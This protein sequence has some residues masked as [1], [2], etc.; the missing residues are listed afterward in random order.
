MRIILIPFFLIFAPS[1]ISSQNVLKTSQ[2]QED[3]KYFQ[4]TVNSD[5][6][7][8]FKKVT[9][10]EFNLAA[11]NLI[12][13]LPKL[14]EHEIKVRI[15]ELVALFK[16]GHT[17]LW[18]S[19]WRY[20]QIVKFRQL[21]Y[22]LYQFKDGVYV[23][24]VHKDYSKA[25]G[26]K[27]IKIGAFST[28]EALARIKPVV[29]VENDQFFKAYGLNY[30][31]VP[32]ILN[33]KGI[34]QDMNR[35][36]LTLERNGDDF[37]M[38]F[39]ARD[40]E[41]FPGH[42]GFVHTSEE[43][44]SARKS[45][46][47][48]FWLKKLDRKYFYEFLKEDKIIYVRQSEVQDEEDKNLAAFYEEVFQF[49]EENDVEKLV[50]DL[51]LNGGGNN[52]K[53]KPVITGLIKS[54][55]INQKGKLFVILGRRTF[56]A[57]QN[58]VNELENYT[59]ATFVGEATAENVNFY[60]D[61]KTETLPNSKLSIRLSFLWWQDKDPRDNR[62]WTPPHVSVEMSISD[63]LNNIDPVMETIKELGII[64]SSSDPWTHL[65]DLFG[66][67]KF[68]EVII[69]GKEYVADPKFSYIDFEGK[70]NVVGTQL[71]ANNQEKEA[72]FLLKLNTEL[73][74]QSAI[75]WF[76][77]G[78]ILRKTKKVEKAKE[79]YSKAIL[80]DPKGEIGEKSKNKLTKLKGA[81]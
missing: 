19:S 76:S 34:I 74:P 10:E 56:S 80:L 24:G 32:E 75:C 57:C 48:P 66:Q 39:K 69:K 33:A 65:A 71:M 2:W 13:E 68:E 21:P 29:S 58:L 8:L 45:D 5:Y 4:N 78:E 11:D 16:Y 77:Y 50:L 53:N 17:A 3:V 46:K 23:E 9:K 62:P 38:E 14:K 15:A 30:L 49:V 63:Y 64:E 37:E 26:A 70:I 41:S 22:N 73:Y 52:Y 12:E 28:E 40:S 55:K 31:G 20:D 60:G 18:L 61:S 36:T 1:L 59:N 72:L 67:G 79:S 25:I 81:H 47:T 51:R 44:L 54:E 6:S 7:F 42:Y 35:V 43:W 27:V